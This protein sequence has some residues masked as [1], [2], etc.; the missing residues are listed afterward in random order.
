MPTP[1]PTRQPGQLP[2]PG[3]VPEKPK[4]SISPPHPVHRNAIDA[5]PPNSLPKE[6]T[7]LFKKWIR[8]LQECDVYVQKILSQA[9]GAPPRKSQ[10]YAT[11]PYVAAR[12]GGLKSARTYDEYV[13][14]QT[15]FLYPCRVF[16]KEHL[17]GATRWCYSSFLK[18]DVEVGIPRDMVEAYHKEDR[19]FFKSP[20]LRDFEVGRRNVH[21]CSS[22]K[23]RKRSPWDSHQGTICLYVGIPSCR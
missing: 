13:T 8:G 4:F 19:T 22:L 14:H 5:G 23:K 7:K 16:D 1:R 9:E 21:F 12:K 10:H 11:K 18:P 2:G 17:D 6:G 20:Y 3:R 15:V